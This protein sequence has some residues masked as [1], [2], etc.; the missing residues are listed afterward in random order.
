MRPGT[1]LFG[2]RFWG[3]LLAPFVL[4]PSD[5]SAQSADGRQTVEL[6]D[7]E[8]NPGHIQ[9]RPGDTL[10]FVNRDKFEHDVYIVRTANRNVV[11]FPPT[12]I[13]AGDTLQVALA[14]KGLFNL[15]CTIHGG[16]TG[17]ITTTGS[18]EL[19][20]AE[21][22]EVGAMKT[23]P[24]I[25][26]TGEELF[27]GK[28]QCHRCHGM[29][30][31]GV[32]TRGP[33]LADIGFRAGPRAQRLGLG[34]ATDYLIQSIL[35]P[36]AYVVEGYTH[37]MATVYQPPVDLDQEQ[38]QAIV[39]YLQSQGGE[40]DSWAI[41]IDEQ[42]LATEPRMNPFRNGDAERGAQVWRDMGCQSCHAVGDA[43]GVSA[44][45]DLTAIGA[46]RSWT[47]LAESILEPNQEI[48]KDWV[49]TTVTYEPEDSR[50]VSE[51]SVQGFLRKNTEQEVQILTMAKEI[52]SLPADRV[53]RIEV[54]ENSKMPTNYGELLTFEQASDLIA[55][56]QSIT[57]GGDSQ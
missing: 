51:K 36:N 12:T 53:I 55:Y 27:W 30:D 19:T 1:A 57:G 14:E 10:T 50:F 33:N 18:F 41:D 13:L 42:K 2:W 49:Y 47:W 52:M 31:R 43:E 9:A 11:V 25:V 24:P 28:A 39:T 8:F 23:L 48:G 7:I 15:Y 54:S 21:K 22:E 38:I 20:A 32:G 56:L 3:V 40:V 17:Q 4:I 44:G 46:Y 6:T 16:M 34:S 45:P 35:E 37:D 26:K 5:A 29:G